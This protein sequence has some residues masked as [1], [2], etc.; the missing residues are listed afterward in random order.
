MFKFIISAFLLCQV[1]FDLYRNSYLQNK[2]YYVPMSLEA[3]WERFIPKSYIESL[4]LEEKFVLEMLKSPEKKSQFL[5]VLKS[6]GLKVDESD[7]GSFVHKRISDEKSEVGEN[8]RYRYSVG[9]VFELQDF[10]IESD[11]KSSASKNKISS[12]TGGDFNR[13]QSVDLGKS[14][15][16]LEAFPLPGQNVP[17]VW[18]R[19]TLKVLA[20]PPYCA[21]PGIISGASFG[22]D[23]VW[24]SSEGD[25]QWVDCSFGSGAKRVFQIILA[26][27]GESLIAVFSKSTITGLPE[28]LGRVKQS[29]MLEKQGLIQTAKFL[30]DLRVGNPLRFHDQQCPLPLSACYFENKKVGERFFPSTISRVLF[31][32]VRTKETVFSPPDERLLGWCQVG[33]L[34]VSDIKFGEKAI[35]A[36][37]TETPPNASVYNFDTG[38]AYIR[39]QTRESSFKRIIQR[40][41]QSNLTLIMLNLLIIATIGG[42]LIWRKRS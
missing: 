23:D 34:S 26:D 1:E 3:K 14:W 17:I 30:D 20:V 5:S 6:G 19:K 12:F 29:G 13:I 2:A 18:E 38:E 24:Q 41:G 16:C 7:L 33:R 8:R 42:I 40:A 4:D 22:L 32:R 27:E 31:A 37:N 21:I 15:V 39:G 36:L 25:R 9:A 11:R 10:S 28:L 35:L